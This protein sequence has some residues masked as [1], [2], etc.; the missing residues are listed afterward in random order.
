[1]ITM[2]T[3]RAYG[4]FTCNVSFPVVRVLLHS[5]RYDRKSPSLV[6]VWMI[7]SA[8]RVK[9][10]PDLVTLAQRAQE[11]GRKYFADAIQHESTNR[12]AAVSL[13]NLLEEM[14]CSR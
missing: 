7:D 14:H 10:D 8:A 9:D 12:E 5:L 1:M 13:Y 3:G 6:D 11:S 4:F 2:A